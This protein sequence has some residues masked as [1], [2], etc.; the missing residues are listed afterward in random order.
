MRQSFT[1]TDGEMSSTVVGVAVVSDPHVPYAPIVIETIQVF[2]EYRNRGHG[3][4]LLEVLITHAK[5]EFKTLVVPT[6]TLD[7]DY[8]GAF[9]W[10]SERG[11]VYDAKKH[12]L[13]KRWDKD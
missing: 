4:K 13:I 12:A 6:A 8:P 7:Q 1:M 5:N 10:L 11:F 9:V 3:S 2:A